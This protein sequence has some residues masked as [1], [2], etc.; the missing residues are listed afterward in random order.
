MLRSRPSDYY[1]A[2]LMDIQ[3][4]NMDGYQATEIIRG[5]GDARAKIPVIAMTANAFD[6]D[7]KKAL[8]AGMN[9]HVVKPVDLERIFTVLGDVLEVGKEIKN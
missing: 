9:G 2:V 8:S 7:K 4:P 3:M 1:I 5:L 6:E